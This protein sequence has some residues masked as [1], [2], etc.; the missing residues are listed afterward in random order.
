MQSDRLQRQKNLQKTYI[1]SFSDYKSG[2]MISKEIYGKY[3]HTFLEQI[4]LFPEYFEKREKQKSDKNK[5]WRSSVKPLI[6]II[7]DKTKLNT[8]QKNQLFQ[9]FNSKEFRSL[10]KYQQGFNNIN[11]IIN[12]I[13]NIA[14]IQLT[15]KTIYN[16]SKNK[17]T[18]LNKKDFE[19]KLQNQILEYSNK[20]NFINEENNDNEIINN[21]KII[22]NKLNKLSNETLTQISKLNPNSYILIDM[23]KSAI[24]TQKSSDKILNTKNRQ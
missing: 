4:Y 20:I 15:S 9:I 12:L 3:N 10:I 23:I 19:N 22:S 8:N 7:N 13:S 18:A 2:L 17:K 14:I 24:L 5:K 6:E 16:L 1:S 11:D 21:S